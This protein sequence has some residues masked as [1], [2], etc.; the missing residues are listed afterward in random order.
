MEDACQLKNAMVDSEELLHYCWTNY[1][2]SR[3]Q[4]CL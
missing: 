1:Y 3:N 2:Q 4:S